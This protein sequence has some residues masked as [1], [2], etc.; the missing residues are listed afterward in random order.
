LG[1]FWSLELIGKFVELPEE[2]WHISASAI[3]AAAQL[4]NDDS[5]ISFKELQSLTGYLSW[6]SV[7]NW[8]LVVGKRL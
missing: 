8:I 3:T 6:A 5:I 4:G 2:K 1:F 7:S